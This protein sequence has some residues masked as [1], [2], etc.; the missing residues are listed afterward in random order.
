M[1]DQHDIR[2]L[3]EAFEVSSSGYYDW[4]SAPD[5]PSERQRPD[6]QL[7]EQI[8]QIHQQS[9]QTYGAPRVQICLRQNGHRHGRNRIGRLMREQQIS[10]RQRRRFRPLTTDSDHDQ[11]IAPNHLAQRPAPTGPDQV[12]VADITY[13]ATA[14]GWLI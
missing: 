14:E 2:T 12:W 10:G 4:K 1:K 11:P 5:H 6:Q 9:R 13:I 7:K 3:C 8:A